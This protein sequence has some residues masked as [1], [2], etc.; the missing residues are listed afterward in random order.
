MNLA[1]ENQGV[2]STN[3][4][5]MSWGI[6][7]YTALG[8]VAGM[9]AL[10]FASKGQF[11]YAFLLLIAQMIIDATDGIMARRVKVSKVLP[12]FDG[13]EM[14]N[15]IDIFTYAW[16]PV[17]IIY[18]LHVLP[19]NF[20]LLIPI[21][22]S[23][24]AY[25]QVNMKSED[26]FFVGFPTYWNIVAMYLYFLRPDPITSSIIVIIPGILSFIPTRYLYP[27]KNNYY[28]KTTWFLGAIWFAIVSFIL[29]NAK[30]DR[31]LSLIS[32]FFPV[33]YMAMSFYVDYKVRKGLKII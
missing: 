4:K 8:G 12:N 1:S 23:L 15:V 32:L 14:D 18:Q 9:A 28:W 10:I 20:I 25:G 7:L 6:H 31:N 19:S 11:N 13:S 29:L 26:A 22:A 30:L 33:Y 3:Q 16:I 21:F 5:L 17:F 24:Y 2:Y 27:S